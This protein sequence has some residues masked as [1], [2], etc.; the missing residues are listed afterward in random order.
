MILTSLAL[1]AA[2]PALDDAAL[3]HDVRCM[4]ALS[5]AAAAAEEAEM[6]NNIT[7]ITTYFIG[8][9]D[10]RA[11]QA[12][13]AALVESEAKALE[14]GDMEAVITECAGV[15]EKRMGEIEKLGQDKS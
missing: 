6:K 11:P 14:T 8:R 3:R 15:V 5:A 4:A 2:Q 13:L 12:D 9:V 1:I 10:G 7:L